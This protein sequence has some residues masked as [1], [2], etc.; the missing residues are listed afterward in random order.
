MA[1]PLISIR[2][3]DGRTITK[4]NCEAMLTVGYYVGMTFLL[5]QRDQTRPSA[6]PSHIHGIAPEK[7]AKTSLLKFR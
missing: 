4:L 5:R 6:L 2:N 3:Q 1:S 7:T